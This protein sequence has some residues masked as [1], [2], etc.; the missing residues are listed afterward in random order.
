[1]QCKII[2]NFVESV[3]VL[4]YLLLSVETFVVVFLFVVKHKASKRKKD[5]LRVIGSISDKEK[6]NI[7]SGTSLASACDVDTEHSH[8]FL[9]QG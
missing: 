2:L 7:H 6:S 5:S 9:Y 4:Y 3:S 1:M 8:I